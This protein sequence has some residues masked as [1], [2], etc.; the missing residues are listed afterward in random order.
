MARAKSEPKPKV[1][2]GVMVGYW[3]NREKHAKITALLNIAYGLDKHG[4]P[5]MTVAEYGEKLVDE[6]FGK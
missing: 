1:D 3:M 5:N 2:R 4:K 6:E